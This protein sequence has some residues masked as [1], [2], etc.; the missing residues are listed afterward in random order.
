MGWPGTDSLFVNL[1]TFVILL[2]L[3]VMWLNVADSEGTKR[4]WTRTSIHVVAALGVFGLVF[5]LG[6]QVN[7]RLRRRST[8]RTVTKR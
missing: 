5:L 4:G 2:P 3:A 7:D 6:L 1:A 8:P